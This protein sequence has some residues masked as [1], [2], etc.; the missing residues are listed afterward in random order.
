MPLL[1]TLVELPAPIKKLRTCP[2]GHVVEFELEDGTIFRPIL[3]M[4]DGK[5]PIDYPAV[6]MTCG[7]TSEKE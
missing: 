2:N 3:L 5:D 6:C 4:V 1:G 7:W